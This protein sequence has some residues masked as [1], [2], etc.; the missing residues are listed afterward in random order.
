[1]E[2]YFPSLLSR[3]KASILAGLGRKALEKLAKDN[4]IRTYTTKGGH[5]KYFRD[6][7]INF[8]TNN[9]KQHINK[10]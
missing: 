6:D 8:L 1:M 3:N 9:E 7:L 4:I 10:V 5:K 2:I